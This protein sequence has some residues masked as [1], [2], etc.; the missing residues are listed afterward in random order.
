VD[1]LLHPARRRRPPRAA[2]AYQPGI[3]HAAPPPRRIAEARAA[4]CCMLLLR[5][6]DARACTHDWLLAESSFSPFSPK[7]FSPAIGTLLLVG[8]SKAQQ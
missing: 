7:W 2:T 1:L 6:C 3:M 4:A 5:S 8:L